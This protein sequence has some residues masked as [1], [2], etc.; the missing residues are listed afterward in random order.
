VETVVRIFFGLFTAVQKFQKLKKKQKKWVIS[1]LF[2]HCLV[3]GKTNFM[4]KIICTAS[5]VQLKIILT[6]LVA[7]LGLPQL[8]LNGEGCGGSCFMF[9]W[10]LEKLK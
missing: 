4:S 1:L 3:F 9:A 2:M 6:I 8:F 7:F 10:N 5:S